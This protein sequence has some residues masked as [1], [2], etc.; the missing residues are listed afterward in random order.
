MNIKKI[1][2]ILLLTLGAFA[3]S[4]C[5][6]GR[7][8]V[9]TWPGLTADAERAYLTTGSYIYAVDLKTGKEVWHYPESAD[10]KHVY[11]ATPVL[12]NGQLLI[13]SEGTNNAFVSLNPET[14]KESWAE[15]FLGAKSKWI[16]SPLVLNDKIYAPNT[17]GFVYIL[18]M[19][20]K[21]VADPIE[22]GGAL[23]S[24]P[25]AEGNLIYIASLD[26]HLHILDATTN[27][28]SAT[29]DVGGA[30]PSSPL[31]AE[32]GVYVGSFTS[33]V[34]FISATGGQSVLA[35]ATNWV[36]GT[37]VLDG[38]TL[39][40]AD[41]NGNVYSFDVLAKK[42]NWSEVTPDGPIVA[43]PLVAG[44]QIYV[45]SE[46]G[47]FFALDQDAKIVWEK[48]VD[49]DSPKDTIYTTP[50]ATGDLILVAPY[51]AKFL[52]TAY[53]ADGKQAWTFVPEK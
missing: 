43:S 36:W 53:D 42:Q 25:V 10:G 24:A 44:D 12:A 5:S 46:A 48:E 23:W 15:P 18:D 38:A 8:A 21:P 31:I 20:G 11:F 7:T 1:S 33:N 37:P 41:L 4:A 19:D 3:L 27:Q 16:A 17:D 32:G 2:L 52:L 9:T 50:V 47:A 30:I 14:G 39:Y 51:K 6:G 22:V 40:Y 34:E 35:G 26:H 49:A 13:G 45:A 28:I 29:V